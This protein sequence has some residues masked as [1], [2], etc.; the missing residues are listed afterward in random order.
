M[1]VPV[2]QPATPAEPCPYCPPNPYPSPNGEPCP[3]PYCPNQ[4]NP[5]PVP[6]PPPDIQP[7][8]DDPEI[9]WEP[10]RRTLYELTEKFPFCLPWDLM[11]GIQSLE[12][13][14][15]DRKIEVNV[16]DGIWPKMVIDLTMF[17]RIAGITRI[18]LLVIFDLGLI[19]ST[20]RLMGG[21][22]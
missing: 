5:Q 17:D 4:P 6:K 15:W 8:Y 9:N 10:L 13:N 1:P 20:R 22:V 18:V 19:F 11:R 21:D 3:N 7:Y 14:Q 16:G 12:S 2:P